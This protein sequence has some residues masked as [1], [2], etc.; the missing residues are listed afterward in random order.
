[1][2]TLTKKHYKEHVPNVGVSVYPN[3]CSYWYPISPLSLIVAIHTYGIQ[4]V[5]NDCLR[6]S[7]STS[8][9]SVGDELNFTKRAL[10]SMQIEDVIFLEYLPSRLVTVSFNLGYLISNCSVRQQQS[11]VHCL[12]NVLLQQIEHHSYSQKLLWLDAEMASSAQ[13]TLCA[14]LVNNRWTHSV[15]ICS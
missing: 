6:R 11:G 15:E 13:M 10:S 7:A 9:S 2:N 3:I 4:Q 14:C 8:S 12:C 1:M 5:T